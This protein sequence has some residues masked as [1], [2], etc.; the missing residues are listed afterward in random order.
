ML[1]AIAPTCQIVN[2]LRLTTF[3]CLAETLPFLT[4]LSLWKLWHT[5]NAQLRTDGFYM[6]LSHH[7][8][9]R[10]SCECLGALLAALLADFILNSRWCLNSMAA[11]IFCSDTHSHLHIVTICLCTGQWPR[12][13]PQ[14]PKG[15]FH[16]E[17]DWWFAASD[18]RRLHS[19]LT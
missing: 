17:R 15:L 8:V 1:K 6:C 18:Y 3:F 19:H 2:K 7:E 9:C 14:A 10:R 11:I 12:T 16:Q 5:T 13:D 4:L